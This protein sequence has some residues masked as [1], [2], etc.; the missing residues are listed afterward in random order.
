MMIIIFDFKTLQFFVI[1][2]QLLVVWSLQKND[3]VSMFWVICEI[4]TVIQLHPTLRN[5]NTCTYI[6]KYIFYIR[7]NLIILIWS[8]Q[9]GFS[10]SYLGGR[11]L[12]L[13]SYIL[14][15]SLL[16]LLAFWDSAD[17]FSFIASL[18]VLYSIL[19]DM[20]Y[21][22]LELQPL[23]FAPLYEPAPA[24]ST[25]VKFSITN[26]TENSIGGLPSTALQTNMKYMALY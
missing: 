7:N 12:F 25:H 14:F 3:A 8:N 21:Y 19:D 24:M 15:A 18:Q 4:N 5:A 16:P 17:Y 20:Y 9:P 1:D 2:L 10:F 23:N 26:A 13:I 6:I 22:I 11:F